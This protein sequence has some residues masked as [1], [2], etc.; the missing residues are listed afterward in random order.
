MILKVLGLQF[1]GFFFF[2][3]RVTL[4]ACSPAQVQIKS[5]GAAD[6]LGEGSVKTA[7]AVLVP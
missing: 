6:E 5:E 1:E 7:G 3:V 4:H 2:V